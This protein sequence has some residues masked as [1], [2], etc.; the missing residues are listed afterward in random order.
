MFLLLIQRA[1]YA[2]YEVDL[3]FRDIN[4]SYA[5]DTYGGIIV[6]I[7]AMW[8]QSDISLISSSLSAFLVQPMYIWRLLFDA[9]NIDTKHS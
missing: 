7:V 5:I 8:V 2:M 3:S 6:H 9:K 4:W 1:I